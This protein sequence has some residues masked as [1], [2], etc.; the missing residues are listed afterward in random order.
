MEF[1]SDTGDHR[2]FSITAWGNIEIAS[3]EGAVASGLLPYC[4]R[5]QDFSAPGKK[6]AGRCFYFYIS[7]D[8]GRNAGLDKALSWLESR[9]ARKV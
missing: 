7:S 5:V 9:S 3:L 8:S 1:V 6:V 2:R 4:M